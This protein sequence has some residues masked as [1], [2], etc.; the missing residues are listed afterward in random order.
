MKI[1]DNAYRLCLPSHLKT[2]DVS[3]V[4]HLRPCFVHPD[5]AIV[6]SRVSSFQP[7]E[8][9]VGGSELDDVELSDY[10]LTTLK[11][12]EVADQSKDDRK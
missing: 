8:T 3:N 9:N 4:K 7:S 5:E 1:N 12:L 10:T 11:Y 6:N 2:S